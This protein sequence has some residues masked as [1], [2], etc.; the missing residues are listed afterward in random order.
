[1]S[2]N[3]FTSFKMPFQK[4]WTI[5]MV[6]VLLFFCTHLSA[7]FRIDFN[8][9]DLTITVRD[10]GSGEEL[11]G[12]SVFTD[13]QKFV[14]FT[15]IQGQVQLPVLSHREIVNFSYVGYDELR[16]PYFEL[17]KDG[18]NIKMFASTNLV[19]SIVVVGRRDDPVE[20]IPYIVERVTQEQIAFTNSQ[21]PADALAANADVFVQK[22]QL[23][24][25]SPIIRGFEANKLLLVIDG[26]RMNNAIY[27]SGH[28]Q[29]SITLDNAI[30]DQAEVIYGPGSLM[31]GSDALG[32]VIHFRTRDPKI[33]YDLSAG[34]SKMAVG[35]YTRFSSANREKALHLDLD[36]RSREWGTMTSLTFANYGDLRV[37]SNRPTEFPNQSIRPYSQLRIEGQDQIAGPW[38]SQDIL[39]STGYS[40]FDLLQKVKYQPSD[41]LYFIL[42][43]QYST[44]TNVPRFD[45]LQ[46]T[47]GSAQE[48][49]WSEW[50][51]GPQK[52]FLSSLKVRMLKPNFL[53]D[54]GTIIGA[55]QK[56][57]EDRLKRKFAGA[58]RTF[59]NEEVFV[60]SLTLDFD[61]SLNKRGT[62]TLSYGL[63]GAYNQVYSDAG[64]IHI[65][66]GLVSR[67]GVFTRYPSDQ[68]STTAMGGYLNYKIRSRDSVFVFNAG[69]RYS[70]VSLFAKYDSADLDLIEWPSEYVN[71]GVTAK[72]DDLTWGAGFTINTKNKWQV[73]ALTST[74]FR[75]P[76]IDDFA[77]LRVQ[78]QFAVLPNTDLRPERSI[79]GELTLGK[80]FGRAT[81]DGGTSFR[82]SG[83]GFYTYL[84]DAIVRRLST[85][86]NGDST[87]IVENEPN[88]LFNVQQNINQNYAIVYG[89]SG[90]IEFK[91]KDT[92][93]LK[94]GMSYTKGRSQLIIDSPGGT[95]PPLDTLVP[96]AHIP[97]RYGQVG[98]MYKK[99]RFKI[100]GIAR[101]AAEKPFSEYAVTSANY[102]TN[103]NLI[104]ERGGSSDNIEFTPHQLNENGEI[105]Y[106]GALGWTTYNLYS[107]LKLSQQIT[108]NLA[109]ENLIDLNYIPFSS[110]IGAPGRNFILTIRGKF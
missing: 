54:K 34:E 17:R 14:G 33:L 50:Y 70:T 83:T 67:G 44:S 45:N 74:A 52:R 61:K 105:Q 19:D 80:E 68:S 55:F 18:G 93:R 4:L 89:W 42:N 3:F 91:I 39:R 99:G 64:K 65:T 9:V 27:R 29:N 87:I 86:P 77:K 100:E 110:G 25:G 90:N 57:D 1:M 107:S 71:E 15:D 8:T 78:N 30:I 6:M 96:L 5:P 69:A 101:F 108:V 22:S 66:T 106:L 102:D 73:R 40:Q 23:G 59:N 109:V 98:L 20:E 103:K 63:D 82:M 12:V 60:Y 51:Y 28:L 11:V 58:Q 46:D 75:S 32:G 85:Q 24:G 97:P 2:G 36:Y 13:D 56:I 79:S 7:N 38:Q 43:V 47:L 53:Y 41:S 104:L 88:P 95:V 21:T 84:K 49:K 26:V 35:A 62:H 92:W 72:N 94:A 48:L 10:G 81:P 76:N 16:I 37:G 31:Y